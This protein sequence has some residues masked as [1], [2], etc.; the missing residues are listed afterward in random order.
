MKNL[1]IALAVGASLLHAQN[2]PAPSSATQT[3]AGETLASDTPTTSVA[4]NTFIAP[5]DWKIRVA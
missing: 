2:P 4:G 1:L 3:A 5:K